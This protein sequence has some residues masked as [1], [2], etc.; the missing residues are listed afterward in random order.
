MAVESEKYGETRAALKADPIIQEM[1]RELIQA[2]HADKVDPFETG[3]MNVALRQYD[4][5]GGTIKGHIG[6]PIEAIREIIIEDTEKVHAKMVSALER[7]KTSDKETLDF[8]AEFK[9]ELEVMLKH[10]SD[11]RA[12]QL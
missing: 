4:E 1:A 9:G 8:V 7:N 5:R 3:L 12:R 11:W 2:W 6:G 10:I